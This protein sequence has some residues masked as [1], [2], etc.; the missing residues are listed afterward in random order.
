MMWRDERVGI[1]GIDYYLP[2]LSDVFE[3]C[4]SVMVPG[5]FA[6][7]FSVDVSSIHLT[8]LVA[9]TSLSS[10]QSSWCRNGRREIRVCAF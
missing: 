2:C 5:K 10:L 6:F 8:L 1:W 9:I 7:G 4:I 3:R